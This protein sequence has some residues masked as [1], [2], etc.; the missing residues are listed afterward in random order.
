MG[1]LN[2]R[3]LAFSPRFSPRCSRHA[4]NG[5]SERVTSARGSA[6]SVISIIWAV[7][8]DS[9]IA[10]LRDRCQ[11]NG[12]PSYTNRQ[13]KHLVY[14]R[15]L[16]ADYLSPLWLPLSISFAGPRENANDAAA[17]KYTTAFFLVAR[18]S[19]QELLPF[20][21]RSKALEIFLRS[22]LCKSRGTKVL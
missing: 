5:H 22:L 2:C 7:T 17:R 12:E 18:A 8:R 13:P 16:S 11:Q 21:S 9:F 14:R 3:T 20:V 15:L 4:S 1:A 10:I 19:V 6:N